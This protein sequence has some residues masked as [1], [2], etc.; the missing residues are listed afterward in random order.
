MTLLCLRRPKYHKQTR[1]NSISR[2]KL[3]HSASKLGPKSFS[4]WNLL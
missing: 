2:F 3:L 1:D 4:L